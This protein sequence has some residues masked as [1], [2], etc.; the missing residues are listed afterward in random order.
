VF[1]VKEGIAHNNEDTTTKT[2]A[3]SRKL[4]ACN[5]RGGLKLGCGSGGCLMPGNG[6]RAPH[7][8]PLCP[9]RARR[10]LRAARAS[11]GEPV[12]F[13][14]GG[15]FLFMIVFPCLRAC[16]VCRTNDR[17][18]APLPETILSKEMKNRFQI[19]YSFPNS[20]YT[21]YYYSFYYLLDL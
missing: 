1:S 12:V 8:Q 19:Y 15:S 10:G 3:A 9:A 4:G 13:F 18:Q 11:R 21:S 17:H 16:N 7:C 2:R 14:L 20:L 5:F 6:S